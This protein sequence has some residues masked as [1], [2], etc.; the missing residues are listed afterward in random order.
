M[1]S[2]NEPASKRDIVQLRE[3]MKQDVLQLREEMNHQYRDVVERI[4]DSET[5]VLKAIFGL[6]E[7]A[8]VRLTDCERSDAAIRERL[9]NVEHRLTDVEKRINLPPQTQ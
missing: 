8:Q 4:A 3:E 9:A 1:N 2:G 5:R 7:S 6:A